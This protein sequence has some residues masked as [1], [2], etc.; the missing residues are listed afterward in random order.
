[1]AVADMDKALHTLERCGKKKHTKLTEGSKVPGN[2]INCIRF[3]QRRFVL[4]AALVA[5]KCT[6]S[7]VKIIDQT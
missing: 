5:E 4:Q 2:C 6:N 3:M 1:M 7:E